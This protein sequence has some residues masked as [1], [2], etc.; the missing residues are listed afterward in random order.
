M[1]R[2]FVPIVVMMVGMLMVGFTFSSSKEAQAAQALD[3]NQ[4]AY[5]DV[6]ASTLWTNP[7]KPREIDQ[8]ALTNPVDLWQWTQSMTYEQ[9]LW[10]TSAGAVQ[11]QALYGDQVTVLQ[12]EGDW[13]KIAAHGQPNPKN[14]LG[15]PAWVPK[16]QITSSEGFDQKQDDPF[17]LVTS[18]TAW[19]HNSE[20]LTDQ[21]LEI[22]MNTRLPVVNKKEGA[23]EVATPA[24]GNKW[25]SSD[26]ASV[27]NTDSDIPKPTGQ[28]LVKTAKEFLGLPYLWAGNSGFGFDC[29]GFTHTVFQ[30]HGK[31]IPRDTTAQVL[32]GKHVDRD[33]L[34]PGDLIYFAHDHGNGAVHH[35]GMYI[36]DGKMIN[37]PNASTEVRIDSISTSTWE[38]EY[39]DAR[40]Y[41]TPGAADLQSLVKDY[42]KSEEINDSA[43]HALDLHLTAVHLFE[44]KGED[45][46]VAK[47]MKGFKALI[48]HQKEEG[49][50]SNSA[51]ETL[52]DDA[53]QMLQN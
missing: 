38:D 8:P 13:V 37:S 22:S 16:I 30:T 9:K 19:L 40:R 31:T 25:I 7:D 32:D 21:F 52:K 41:F 47:H 36:G 51:Y 17:A 1:K 23:I 53:D 26:D 12:E 3:K 18:T 33:A 10:L 48:Q 46:K 28:D 35:V 34:L 29:S 11:T 42:K 24:E 6:A 45:N 2:F 50:I 39:A 49:S 5:V 4:D 43:A 14:D 44:K 15:Y 20:E 27:Y